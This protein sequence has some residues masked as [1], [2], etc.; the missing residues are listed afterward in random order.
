MGANVTITFSLFDK[1]TAGMNSIQQN[2][3]RTTEYMERLG[4]RMFK[5][6]ALSQGF[7][8]FSQSFQ[9][10]TRPGMEFQSAMADLQAITGVTGKTLDELQTKARATAKTFGFE[11]AKSV[12]S[13]KLLLS[14]LTPELAKQPAAL[15]AM[16]RNVAL[17]SKTMGGDTT[18]ATEVLTTAMNQYQVSMED[19]IRASQVMTEMMNIMAAGAKEGSA[20]LPAIKAALEQ[21][22][23]AAKTFNVP[24]PKPLQQLKCSTRQ[25]KR[26]PRVELPCAM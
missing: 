18:A 23:M 26:A 20:E 16:S 17:L 4:D 13:Y 8:N 19:P 3:V 7:S 5:I 21:S 22:G 2:F 11:G 25:G 14:Q 15:D 24:L 6:N 12:E 9:E 1:V 10:A